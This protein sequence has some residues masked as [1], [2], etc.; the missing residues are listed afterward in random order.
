MY[1]DEFQKLA[2][3]KDGTHLTLN[4]CPLA[5]CSERD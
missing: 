1:V 2:I 4:V 3:A 5:V